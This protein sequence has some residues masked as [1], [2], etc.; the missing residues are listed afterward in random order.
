MLSGILRSDLAIE[1][2]IKI[3]NA[4]VN[5]RKFLL[6]N[7]SI[8][9]KTWKDDWFNIKSILATFFIIRSFFE[10]CINIFLTI[11]KNANKLHSNYEKG[12]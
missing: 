5:M 7:A 1:I 8:F 3:M 9:Q 12:N 11:E 6:E 2:S 4:F 10:L